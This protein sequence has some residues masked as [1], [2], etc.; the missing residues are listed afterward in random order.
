VAVGVVSAAVALGTFFAVS[1][2]GQSTTTL[3]VEQWRVQQSPGAVTTPPT[4]TP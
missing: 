1:G 4:A 3:P 2:V